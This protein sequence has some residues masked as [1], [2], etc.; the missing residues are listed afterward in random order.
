MRRV[1]AT[2][3]RIGRDE[4][5]GMAAFE[6]VCPYCGETHPELVFSNHFIE[7]TGDFELDRECEWCGKSVTVECKDAG[8][9]F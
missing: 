2:N 8:A 7:V 3:V 4:T 6:W 9:P 5:G 1:Q